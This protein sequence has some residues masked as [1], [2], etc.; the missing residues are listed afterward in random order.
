[1]ADWVGEVREEEKGVGREVRK[2]EEGWYPMEEGGCQ[3]RRKRKRKPENGRERRARKGG[4]GR[5]SN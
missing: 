4:R 1:M 5:V 3:H 2:E